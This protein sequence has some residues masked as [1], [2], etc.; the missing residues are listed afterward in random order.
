MLRTLTRWL[1]V[2]ALLGANSVLAAEP[3][4]A[5]ASNP[6]ILPLASITNDHD[7]SVSVLGLLTGSGDEVSGVSIVTR[8]PDRQGPDRIVRRSYPLQRVETPRGIV[9]TR[10]HGRDL[11]RLHGRIDSKNGHGTLVI[12]YLSNALFGSHHDCRVDLKRIEPDRWQLIDVANGQPIDRIRVKTWL[13]GIST[14]TPV[15]Q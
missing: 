2:A 1:C 14:I 9:L 6:H 4:A 11:I 12:R 13:L 15:C 7:P 3:A 5:P 10:K 8:H